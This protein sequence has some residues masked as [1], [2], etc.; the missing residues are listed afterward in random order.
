MHGID[1]VNAT[2]PRQLLGEHVSYF[3]NPAVAH[4]V[5]AALASAQLGHHVEPAVTV[6]AD[7]AMRWQRTLNRY[8]WWG[9]PVTVGAALGV[10]WAY[11]WL[12]NLMV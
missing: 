6:S 5:A 4:V 8:W 7:G 12:A 11:P 9:L 3:G 2:K 1:V 10:L